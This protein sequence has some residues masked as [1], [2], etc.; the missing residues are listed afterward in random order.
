MSTIT[1]TTT[2]PT[3]LIHAHPADEQDGVRLTIES[4]YDQAT[5]VIAWNDEHE[6]LLELAGLHGELTELLTR[7]GYL[8]E[9]A[10]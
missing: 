10:A 6:G 2:H 7:A 4:T 1:V 5:T 3:A 8:T 9:E